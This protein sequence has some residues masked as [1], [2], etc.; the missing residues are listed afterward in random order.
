MSLVKGSLKIGLEE[1]YR[2]ERGICTS[3]LRNL[4]IGLEEV[5]GGERGICTSLV[6]GSVKKLKNWIGGS[7][8]RGAWY[9]HAHPDGDWY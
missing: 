8:R 1:V 6:K 4:N 5:Y 9:G 3:Q 7:V 2:A